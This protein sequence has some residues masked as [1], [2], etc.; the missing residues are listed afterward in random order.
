MA[1]QPLNWNPPDD[2][3]PE[4]K[5]YVDEHFPNPADQANTIL[6]QISNPF[7]NPWPLIFF[8]VEVL[9][10][11]ALPMFGRGTTLAQSITEIGR[12]FYALHY[13]KA[14]ELYDLQRVTKEE[15]DE[16]GILPISQANLESPE[17]SEPGSDGSNG[18]P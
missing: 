3:T 7:D 4:W 5:E 11:V 1:D 6:E 13:F 14:P 9:G 2:L 17:I 12:D 8:A 16:N 10:N 15:V 18:S